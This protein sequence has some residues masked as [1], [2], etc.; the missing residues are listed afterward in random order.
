MLTAT[1][2]IASLSLK[3]SLHLGDMEQFISIRGVQQSQNI[4][5][6]VGDKIWQHILINNSLLRILTAM[7][8]F[9]GYSYCL[10]EWYK[11]LL[12]DPFDDAV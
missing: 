2:N 12:L 10:V 7:K 11:G 8:G 3:G 4:K 1:A 9:S 5:K 6:V